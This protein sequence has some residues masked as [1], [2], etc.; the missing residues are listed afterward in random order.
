MSIMFFFTSRRRHTRCALVTGVQTC[1]LPIYQTTRSRGDRL[2]GGRR[3]AGAE[4]R[5]G[6]SFWTDALRALQQAA[7]LQ[8]KVD[9]ALSVAEE[10]RRHSIETRERVIQIEAFLDLAA[11]HAGAPPLPERCLQNGSAPT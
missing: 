6:M 11:R 4:A 1:A 5:R 3:A 9:Q 10:A 7:L 8:Y 2:V